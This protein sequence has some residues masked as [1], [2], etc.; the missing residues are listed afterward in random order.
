M[1]NTRDIRGEN[2]SS[3]FSPMVVT[4]LLVCPSPHA[5]Q[6]QTPKCKVKEPIRNFWLPLLA[7]PFFMFNPQQRA[8]RPSNK[9]IVSFKK[10][11]LYEDKI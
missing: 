9:F 4:H 11:E 6:R 2:S 8:H 5:R 10:E 1:D 7:F 3:F